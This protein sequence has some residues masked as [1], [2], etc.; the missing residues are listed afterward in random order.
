MI[1]EHAARLATLGDAVDRVHASVVA[2]ANNVTRVLIDVE[3]ILGDNARARAINHAL[4]N[5]EHHLRDLDDLLDQLTERLHGIAQH[6]TAGPASAKTTPDRP[7]ASASTDWVNQVRAELPANIVAADQRE[8]GMPT[9][10]THGRWVAEDGVVH[11][12]ASG[13]DD[14]YSAA[15][16]F[17]RSQP[18]SRVPLRA[19]D[20][21]MKLAIHMRLSGIT[22]ATLVINHVPCDRGPWSCDR[23]VPAILPR[24][25]T[26]TVHGAGG[27]HKTYQGKATP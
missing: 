25:Y 8:P 9:P 27:F 24:G 15:V 5:A 11:A 17:F 18:G 22:A 6:H 4:G 19:P 12:E 20:V 10:K 23:M 7:V 16:D 21:E 26:L 13:K 14:K 3:R 2:L 1:S